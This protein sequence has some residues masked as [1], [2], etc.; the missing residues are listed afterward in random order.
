MFGVGKEAEVVDEME[1][2]KGNPRWE[3]RRLSGEAGMVVLITWIWIGWGDPGERKGAIRGCVAKVEE[4]G[5]DRKYGRR[6]RGGEERWQTLGDPNTKPWK[7]HVRRRC[8]RRGGVADEK[9]G[10]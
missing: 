5:L 3:G 7:R 8:D 9:K 6:Y 4:R 2:A 1:R 10:P